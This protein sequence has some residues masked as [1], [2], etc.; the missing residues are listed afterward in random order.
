MTIRL[1]N[2][3]RRVAD[4]RAHEKNN[5]IFFVSP[6]RLC[7]GGF[8]FCIDDLDLIWHSQLITPLPP[9]EGS[10]YFYLKL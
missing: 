3:F 10:I 7:G 5:F 4:L 2:R 6:S 8:C 1:G 9:G